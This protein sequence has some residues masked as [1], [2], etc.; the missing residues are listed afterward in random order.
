MYNAVSGGTNSNRRDLIGLRRIPAL[1]NS[2]AHRS[3]KAMMWQAQEQKNRPK[4]IV[5]T[6]KVHMNTKPAVMIPSSSVYMTSF[7]SR[8]ASVLPDNFQCAM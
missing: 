4:I 2:Q 1:D 7:N 3:C 8:G 6:H 5:P